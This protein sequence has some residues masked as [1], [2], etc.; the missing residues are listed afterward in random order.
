[1]LNGWSGIKEYI[2]ANPCL[3]YE[4]STTVVHSKLS[5][6][7]L[8]NGEHEEGEVQ[9]EFYDAIAADSSSSSED[10]ESGNDEHDKKVSLCCL[11]LC[12]KGSTFCV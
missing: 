10:E 7:S 8:S 12:S 3:V 9:D 2:G 6:V 5:D 11:L 4:S 1:M